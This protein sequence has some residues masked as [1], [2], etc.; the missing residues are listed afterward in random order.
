MM[1]KRR[2]SLKEIRL[3]VYTFIPK[4]RIIV[5]KHFFVSWN[6]TFYGRQY[7]FII[8]DVSNCFT[9]YRRPSFCVLR[10]AFCVLRSAKYPCRRPSAFI[11]FS[12]FGYRALSGSKFNV[13]TFSSLNFETSLFAYNYFLIAALFPV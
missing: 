3:T 8:Y 1:Q 10:S 6:S 11:N 9:L 12:V 5:R 2:H 13:Q 7:Q 4:E